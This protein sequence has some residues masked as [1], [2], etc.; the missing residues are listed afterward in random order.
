MSKNVYFELVKRVLVR[1]LENWNCFNFEYQ[2]VWK[3]SKMGIQKLWKCKFEELCYSESTLLFAVVVLVS[4]AM[5]GH[6]PMS[7][8]FLLLTYKITAMF[9]SCMFVIVIFSYA[10]QMVGIVFSTILKC[11]SFKLVHKIICSW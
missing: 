1:V 8:N 7:V 5:C 2:W 6:C 11:F 9:W 3:G 4:E 10:K